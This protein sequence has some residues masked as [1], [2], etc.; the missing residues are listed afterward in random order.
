MVG[1]LGAVAEAVVVVCGPVRADPSDGG[2]GI[3][4][5]AV[6]VAGVGGGPG[7]GQLGEEVVVEALG[8]A[9][10][11]VVAGVGGLGDQAG[12]VVGVVDVVE[13]SRAVA[14]VD[15]GV[16]EPVVCSS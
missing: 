3:A 11:V 10:G 6:G 16:G 4:G 14:C 15:R 2:V 8:F 7:G 5:R 12:G 9:G 13:V 1:L